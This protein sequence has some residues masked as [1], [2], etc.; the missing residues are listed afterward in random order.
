V[1]DSISQDFARKCGDS[2][3]GWCSERGISDRAAGPNGS[4]KPSANIP[5]AH[6]S[7]RKNK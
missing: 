3:W 7:I 1:P 6:M 4:D 2:D 5:G